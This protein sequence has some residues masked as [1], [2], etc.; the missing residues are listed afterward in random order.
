[1]K[2][3]A[4]ALALSTALSPAFAAV[5]DWRNGC[6][7]WFFNANDVRDP[8]IVN[9]ATA[10]PV[11]T[12]PGYDNTVYSIAPCNFAPI[13]FPNVCSNLSNPNLPPSTCPGVP[14]PG[15]PG[16]QWT[17]IYLDQFNDQFG[18]DLSEAKE[19]FITGNGFTSGPDQ[20]KSVIYTW[21][22]TPGSGW[23]LSPISDINNY[24]TMAWPGGCRG[25][26]TEQAMGRQPGIAPLRP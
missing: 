8:T 16:N 4:L 11:G 1:M 5:T 26:P 10:V 21:F 18:N 14:G 2:K 25:R 17:D 9:N 13:T 19:V 6:S 24:G 23:S 7:Q 15:E 3:L 20:W 12:C 22:R